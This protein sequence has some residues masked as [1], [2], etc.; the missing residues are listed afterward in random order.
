MLHQLEYNT[1]VHSETKKKLIKMAFRPPSFHPS[2]MPRSPRTPRGG[3]ARVT[4][5]GIEVLVLL[6]VAVAMTV[7]LIAINSSAISTTL[8]MMTGFSSLLPFGSSAV[9]DSFL[10]QYPSITSHQGVDLGLSTASEDTLRA[11]NVHSLADR[12]KL[13]CHLSPSELSVHVPQ[14]F[15]HDLSMVYPTRICGADYDIY[16]TT[17]DQVMVGHPGAVAELLHRH[18]LGAPIVNF[19]TTQPADGIAKIF[20]EIEG[21][22]VSMKEVVAADPNGII[23]QPLATI[24]AVVVRV[25]TTQSNTVVSPLAKGNLTRFSLELKLDGSTTAKEIAAAVQLVATTLKNVPGAVNTLTTDYFPLWTYFGVIVD[26]LRFTKAYGAL[27]TTKGVK[28]WNGA[29]GRESAQIKL[30]GFSVLATVPQLWYLLPLRDRQLQDLVDKGPMTISST[31]GTAEISHQ[32][33]ASDLC[34]WLLVSPHWAVELMPSVSFL[35]R[36]VKWY[37]VVV[38]NPISVP[39]QLNLVEKRARNN[40]RSSV[41]HSWKKAVV[42]IAGPNVTKP[43]ITWIV[44]TVKDYGV[45]KRLKVKEGLNTVVVVSNVAQSLAEE[46]RRFYAVDVQ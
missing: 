35:Q 9:G 12:L 33:T 24:A 34:S 29:I 14:Q 19:S 13:M 18:R 22:K 10:D 25:I 2:P 20:K 8:R 43:L 31:D 16:F 36:C 32:V 15:H 45:V 39:P 1:Q 3:S 11:M 40:G 7:I 41:Q 44:D 5:C 37:D 26:P 42:A 17:D 23:T 28:K 30:E 21:R 4:R 46:V 38:V 27:M 6:G